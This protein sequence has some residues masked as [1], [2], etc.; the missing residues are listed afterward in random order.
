MEID[1]SPGKRLGARDH[2]NI[3]SENRFDSLAILFPVVGKDHAGGQLL[4]YLTQ[5]LVVF[6]D[7][8]I[9]RCNRCR[10][11]ADMLGAERKQCVLDAVAGKDD[12]RAFNRNPV[13]DQEL[14]NA[15][16]PSQRIAIS[17]GTP[18][19]GMIALRH[20]DAVR[21]R[22]CPFYQRIC[23]ALFIGTQRVFTPH[24]DRTVGALFH[25]QFGRPSIDFS[26]LALHRAFR[27]RETIEGNCAQNHA[28]V[29]SVVNAVS[30]RA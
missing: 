3:R 10:G 8:R 27:T 9:G 23:Y 14:G 16:N 18:I 20:P 2:G 11:N 5:F 4:L 12:E 22:P 1:A 15:A 29:R 7:K 24:E 19:S 17:D 6:G 25:G 28:A 30:V 21:N 26:D 13:I